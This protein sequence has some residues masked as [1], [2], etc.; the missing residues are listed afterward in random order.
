MLIV[1]I[2]S[3]ALYILMLVIMRLMGKRQI[4]ELQPGEFA[5]TMMISNMAVLPI[6]DANIPML[7]G[8]APILT[9]AC[10]EVVSSNIGIKSK[11]YRKFLSGNPIVVIEG[12]KIMQ[13]ALHDIRYSIDDLM[14]GLRSKDIFDIKE[15]EYAI[16]ETDGTLNVLQKFDS[17]NVTAKMLNLDGKTDPPPLVVISDGKCID[18]NINKLKITKNWVMDEI[19]K[20]NLKIKEIFLMTVNSSK[21]INIVKRER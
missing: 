14:S 2:R 11:R 9:L 15:V 13:K 7:I 3:L 16:V 21:E 17:Q 4:G 19:S 5:I 10:F 12:G 20:K 18:E 6:E 1:F 8:I